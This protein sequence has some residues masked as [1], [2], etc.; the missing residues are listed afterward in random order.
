M[1]KEAQ[2]TLEMPDRPVQ[3]ADLSRA[4][5]DPA[6]GGGWAMRPCPPAFAT[7]SE[8]RRSPWE[9]RPK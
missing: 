2:L 4:Q 9:I 8:G 7:N 6:T 1:S 3:M 5:A